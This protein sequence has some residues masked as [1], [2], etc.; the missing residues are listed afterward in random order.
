MNKRKAIQIITGIILSQLGLIVLQT[1]WLNQ[2]YDQKEKEFLTQLETAFKRLYE[3]IDQGD[4]LQLELTKFEQLSEVRKFQTI[5]AF[6]TKLHEE[7]A[8]VAIDT[9]Y[10]FQLYRNEVFSWDR[11]LSQHKPMIASKEFIYSSGRKKVDYW[12]TD[13]C[14]NCG[15][16][17]GINLKE[18]SFW[19]FFRQV[20]MWLLLSLFFIVLQIFIFFYVLKVIHRQQKLS[21]LKA[22]LINQVTHELNT[23]IFSTSL[24]IKHLKRSTKDVDQLELIGIIEEEQ[25]RLKGNV[26][27][28]L[29][30]SKMESK[31]IDLKKEV[32]DIHD[33]IPKVLRLFH[34]QKGKVEF[35]VNFEATRSELLL[36]QNLL[37]N[38]VFNV[39]DNSIKYNKNALIKVGISTCN[40]ET[41]DVTITITDNGIGIPDKIQSKV[42]D[43]FY[44]A[45]LLKNEIKGTG[46]GL[47]YT[48]LV[49][50][51]HHGKITLTSHEGQGTSISI[52]LPAINNNGY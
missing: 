14:R 3:R 45:N 19:Y 24:A 9:T 51:A 7:L 10:E 31:T 22:D 12:V 8:L 43:K 11:R 41:G 32:V 33:L 23:P 40:N 1:V 52:S 4:Q 15:L 48:A 36:D 49:V 29:D 30:I 27:R 46:L 38:A 16:S 35:K 5:N 44:R 39:I 34:L 20:L 13:L 25:K 47:S 26:E 42:F 2:L 18:I 50:E 17:L 28:M 21:E 37:I 6:K